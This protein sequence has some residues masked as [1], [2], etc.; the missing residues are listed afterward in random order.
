MNLPDKKGFKKLFVRV[1]ANVNR[2]RRVLLRKL[3]HLA[4]KSSA[5]KGLRKY[6][7]LGFR[8]ALLKLVFFAKDQLSIRPRLRFATYTILVLVLILFGSAQI[9]QELMDNKAEIKVGG[10][11]VLVAIDSVDQGEEEEVSGAV[12][13]KISP[14][15]YNNPVND[16]VVSQGFASYH[17][18]VDIATSLGSPI[19]PIGSGTVEFTGYSPDGK[20]NIV[21]VNH[22]DGLK[23]LY[24]HMGKIE[25]GLGNQVTSE[26][27]LGEVGLTGRTTGAHLHLEVYDRETAM[28]PTQVLP[29]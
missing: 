19:R 14:F 12:A 16:G 8:K 22:G 23:T 27:V 29:N 20:G 3:R 25:V 10:Q 6:R 13:S 15:S 4:Y 18:A 2:N 5:A 11:A 9:A 1:E 21:I 26:S 7:R 17:R 28:N 24:A